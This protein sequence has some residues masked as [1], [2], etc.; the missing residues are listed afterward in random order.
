MRDWKVQTEQCKAFQVG[1]VTSSQGYIVLMAV[2][3]LSG[4]KVSGLA[5]RFTR[6]K[7]G[8]SA[9]MARSDTA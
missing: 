4:D 1:L 6:L 7:S 2:Y 8:G 5:C 9:N 3:T